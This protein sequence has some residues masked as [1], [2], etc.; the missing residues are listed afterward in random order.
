MGFAGV[1]QRLIVTIKC[2]RWARAKLRPN[3]EESSNIV[4]QLPDDRS[5]EAVAYQWASQIMTV[6]MEMVLP[7]MLGYALDR[8][9]KTGYFLTICGFVFGFVFGMFHLLKMTRVKP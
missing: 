6:A 9:W 1:S 2:G 7:G 8:R 4:S 5:R 3:A